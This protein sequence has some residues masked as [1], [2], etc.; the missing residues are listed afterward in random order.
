MIA[1]KGVVEDDTDVSALSGE[2][3]AKGG[4]RSRSGR[5]SSRAKSGVKTIGRFSVILASQAAYFFFA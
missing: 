3:G 1:L 5:R 4:N 2:E